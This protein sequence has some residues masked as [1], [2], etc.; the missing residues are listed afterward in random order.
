M[1]AAEL[2]QLSAYT[3]L[4]GEF[5]AALGISQPMILVGHGLGAIVALCYACENPAEVGRLLTVAA[6]LHGSDINSRLASAYSE[7]NVTRLLEKACIHAEVQ[8]EAHKMDRTALARLAGEAATIDLSSVLDILS[9]PLLLTHGVQDSVVRYP[10]ARFHRLGDAAANRVAITF[11]DAGHFPMLESP[12]QF[13]R[14][15]LEFAQIEGQEL[16][17]LAVK[18]HW[19]R[20]TH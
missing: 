14:L 9:C 12:E 3:R 20:R 4:V 1:K 5:R 6:P 18:E 19:R 2:Y 16:N 8:A 15:L 17:T 7:A 13:N 11:D 10:G